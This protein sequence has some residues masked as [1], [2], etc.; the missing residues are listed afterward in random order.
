[1]EISG[2]DPATTDPPGTLSGRDMRIVTGRRF[3]QRLP[4]RL[5]ASGSTLHVQL[6]ASFELYIATSN[7][8]GLQPCS[9][10]AAPIAHAADTL[11]LRSLRLLAEAFRALF[12]PSV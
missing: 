6:Y 2:D 10:C 9:I 12:L 3:F 1:M 8:F 4:G 11:G 5:S 7:Q